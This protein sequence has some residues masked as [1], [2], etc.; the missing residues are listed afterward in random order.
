MCKHVRPCKD[1]SRNASIESHRPHFIFFLH[2]DLFVSPSFR[3]F[4]EFLRESTTLQFLA[5]FQFFSRDLLEICK[6]YVWGAYF[7]VACGRI[8]RHDANWRSIL[9]RLSAGALPAA[10]H[11]PFHAVRSHATRNICAVYAI[12]S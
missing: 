4:S 1:V 7:G 12:G 3:N 8:A 5:E 11:A 2:A 9:T 10:R 6:E